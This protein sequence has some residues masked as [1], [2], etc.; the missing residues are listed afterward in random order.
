MLTQITQT[1]LKFFTQKFRS[2]L[3]DIDNTTAADA[4][5]TGGAKASGAMVLI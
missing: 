4:V 5:A 3:S 1:V 2:F